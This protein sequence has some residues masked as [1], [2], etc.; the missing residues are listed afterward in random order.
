MIPPMKLRLIYLMLLLFLMP[1]QALALSSAWQGD[2]T[3]RVRLISGIDGT[4]DKSTIPLGLD[5][6]LGDTWHT[7]WRSPGMAGL[8][9]DIDWQNSLTDEGNLKKATLLFPAPNR[10]QAYGL[11]TLGYR[12]HV[13]FP[14]DAEPKVTGHTLNINATV[15]LLVCSSICVP[16]T[17][18]LSLTLPNTPALDS[19]EAGLLHQFRDQVPSEGDNSSFLIR[20]IT[21]D[22]GAL[23]VQIDSNLPL[24]SPDIFIESENGLS[25]NAPNV[26]VSSDKLHATF[27][28]ATTDPLPAGSSLAHQKLTLTFVSGGRSL[29]RHVIV[30]D[31]SAPPPTFISTPISL[32]LAIL[33]AIVGGFILNLMPC[34]LPVLSLKILSVIGHG[35]GE[36]R[37][38]RQSFFVTASGILF[39]FI[40]L[41]TLTVSFK[42]LGY[43]FGWG[44]Q[45]QQPLFLLFLVLLLT[46]FATNLWGLAEIQLPQ[47]L[48]D[49]L[50]DAVYH[51]KLAGDFATGA[52]A[53]LLA[54]PC[55][56][57]FLGTALGFALASSTLNIFIIFA[58]LGLG[59][60]LP[61][62][63]IAL[64]PQL[65]TSMPKPGSWM[66]GLRRTL[67]VALALTAVWFL[68]IVSAQIT[69][70]FA[71]LVGLALTGIVL[72]LAL[73]KVRASSRY[74][75]YSILT[76]I[77]IIFGLGWVG[78]RL[79]KSA[80]EVDQ[81]WQPFSQNRL[82]ADLAEGKTVF[83]DVTADWCLT[84]KANKKFVLTRPPVAERLFHSDIVAMQA[85]W[86]NPDPEI[87][88]FLQKYGRY[89]IPFNA[90]FGPGTQQGLVLPELLTPNLVLEALD[91]AKQSKP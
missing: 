78:D 12:D 87:A 19:S 82:A 54:T 18:L 51:P 65:A 76:L 29:E 35:G 24:E 26:T 3:V 38:V 10:Y 84:C 21:S 73:N 31:T 11:E 52:F 75:Y 37:R 32:G 13:V 6:Q 34:V 60:A 33:F 71:C 63:A 40:L 42:F 47:F 77:L 89:G 23:T 88:A 16:K 55:S 57:P 30:S 28:S 8:P 79:P 69:V 91:E 74:R 62:L 61:Y 17:F 43:A 67:G 66:I 27:R 53:T 68:W 1:T 4:K 64:F 50:N 72:L 86:T 59:M 70:Q 7:Y 48:T 80:A 39:S 83:L 85:D 45:F 2:A 14:I 90:V 41:A 5:V 20:S 9:P 56:A 81:L 36:S 44:I 58:F 46:F 25:F 22:G 49:G 15:N